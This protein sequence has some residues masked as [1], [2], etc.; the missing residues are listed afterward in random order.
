MDP[1]LRQLLGETD[2]GEIEAI[3][4]LA[5]P[6]RTP[7]GVR[8]VARFGETIATCRIAHD[9]VVETWA[10]DAVVSLK[11]ARPFNDDEGTAEGHGAPPEDP[12]PL[13]RRPADLDTT[14]E[15]VIV[16]VIDWGFDFAHD[17][18]RNDDGSTRILALWDQTSRAGPVPQPYGYGHVFSRE[19]IDAALASPRPYAALGY[20]PGVADRG[21]QGCHG[22]HVL[23]IAAGNGRLPGSPMGVAPR[24]EFLL[25]HLATRGTD[26][27]ANL[28][29]SVTLLEGLDWIRRQAGRR[30]WV[31]NMSVGR[32][33]GP[34]T[35]L[36]LVELG[37]D[38]LL[39]EAPGRCVVQSAGNYYASNVHSGGQ[40]RPGETR[41]L[42]WQVGAADRT[43]NEL[44]IW[45]SRHDGLGVTL[46]PPDGRGAMT[47]PLGGDAPILS[48][49]RTVGHFY[50]RA[51]DPSN[52]DNHV[53]IFLETDAPPGEW[54]VRLYG[55]DV[56][57]GR[58][59]CWVERDS[60]CRTCQSRL[61]PQDADP[62]STTGTICNSQRSIA[63]G[64]Y[65]AEDPD[66]PLARFSSAGPTVDGRIKPDLVA[67]G[68]Q[69]WAARSTPRRSHTPRPALVA[70]SGTSMAAPHVTGAVANMFEAA[71]RALSIEETRRLLLGSTEPP[72][73][74]DDP[75]RIGS[76]YL[77]LS[78][79]VAATRA[80]V[81]A[82]PL[83]PYPGERLTP[84]PHPPAASGFPTADIPIRA[85]LTARPLAAAVEATRESP[86]E[87]AMAHERFIPYAEN[88]P[89]DAE[90]L[91]ETAL[92]EAIPGQ[93]LYDA[94]GAP[95]G[96]ADLFDSLAGYHGEAMR[97]HYQQFVEVVGAP[98]ESVAGQLRPGDILL[99][100]AFGEG[101]LASATLITEDDLDAFDES[102]DC[103][104]PD[105]ECVRC[106]RA[107]R[108]RRL[109]RNRLVV[110]PRAAAD[111]AM[112]YDE[113]VE[114]LEW[115]LP[116]DDEES[117][118]DEAV[119]APPMA[120]PARDPV[121]FA[122][123]PP[124]G[125]YW[126]I[127]TSHP[128]GR[129]VNYRAAD[130]SYVGAQAGRAFLAS[131]SSGARYHVGIDLFAN[132]GD[133]VVA[134][135]DGRVISFYG[136]CCGKQMTTNALLVEHS[137]VVVNYGEVAPDSLRRAGLAIGSSVTAGQVI[138][139]VGRNPGGSSMIHF[140]TYVPGTRRNSRF[141]VGSR[142]P[143]PLLNP[144]SYLLWLQTHGRTP[145]GSAGGGAGSGATGSAGTGT[146]TGS[147]SSATGTLGALLSAVGSAASAVME[148]LSNGLW[149]N[150]V[151]LAIAGGQRDPN[152]LTNMVFFA[153]HPERNGRPL[154]Q[155]EADFARL[156]REWLD[157]RNN[158]VRPA[159]AGGASEGLDDDG[160][161]GAEALETSGERA[162]QQAPNQ[163][164]GATPLTDAEWHN[165][166]LWLG[167]G[168]VGVEPLTAD[169]DRNALIVAEAIFCGRNLTRL[170]T[171]TGEDPLLCVLSDVTR[172]DPRV[173]QLV[174]FVTAR[175]PIVHWPRVSEDERILYA[176]RRLV[177]EYRF[178]VNGA[179][180]LVGNLFAESGVLPSRIEGSG[181]ATPLTARHCNGTTATFSA[182]EVMNRTC[183]VSKARP[184]GRSNPGQGPCMPGIGLAQWTTAARRRELFQH[185]F[186]GRPA[187]ARILFDMDAQLDYLNSELTGRP[188][189]AGVDR[190][191]RRPTVGV[192]EASDEVVYNFEIPGAVLDAQNHKLPRSNPAVQAVF[193][194]RRGLSQRALRVY[195]ARHPAAA[196][197]LDALPDFEAELDDALPEQADES[198]EPS[199]SPHTGEWAETFLLDEEVASAASQFVRWV[200]SSLNRVLGLS[201]AVD[202]V[203][204]TQTRQAIR[205]FQ[206]REGLT[207]D[208]I[209]GPQTRSALTRAVQRLGTPGTAA[210][211]GGS[212]GSTISAC[213]GLRSPEVID[214]FEFNRSEVLPSH[215]PQIIRIARCIVASQ[216]TASP[217][218]NLDVVGHTDPVGTDAANLDLG[219]RRA[220][221]VKHELLRTI[222]RILPGTAARIV[223]NA[224][225]QGETRPVSSPDPAASRR[226]EV[227][228]T[229]PTMPRPTVPPVPPVTPPRIPPEPPEVPDNVRDLLRRVREA[230]E[231]VLQWV[232]DA[233]RDTLCP[234]ITAPRNLR[235]L[236]AAEQ[237]EARSVY[238][239]SL[240]FSR[241]IITDGLGCGGRP[242]TVAFPVGSDWWV[243]LN[244]G[245]VAS[246][247][248]RPRSDTLIHELAHAWQSQH[249]G[250]DPTAFMRNSIINQAGAAALTALGLEASAYAYIPGKPFA[251]YGAEQIAEQVEDSYNGTG[252]PTPAVARHVRSVAAG[253]AD[254][255]NEASLSVST[256][257]ERRST[258]G[259]VWP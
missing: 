208:G 185:V 80:W 186:Q 33:G 200:Q 60:A 204:G 109:A 196:E 71:G 79:A 66:R 64:A 161:E 136:F 88:E 94:T 10:D 31:V 14:G 37:I 231:S 7:P 124:A 57:D 35:G 170:V 164:I 175:G 85:G 171:G 38:A 182:E 149:P 212:S 51:R 24:A 6:P 5:T 114:A 41:R 138:G 52:G 227:F 248:T 214:R 237:A 47:V 20:H 219:R 142:R 215:Q 167:R 176:M 27:E 89:E 210:P 59:N 143:A 224:S 226:V 229:L 139:Y 162:L 233:V 133:P 113:D 95:A 181:M 251:E 32:H 26:G 250:S 70:N 107:G 16:A 239:G 1:A 188:G 154:A 9:Q 48:G 90:A 222:D 77:D 69:V 120:V 2:S 253:V 223:I 256:A 75:M 58:Y 40:L 217:I 112:E 22:T 241:I 25:V 11:A 137:N 247:A 168:E 12:A 23:D 259:V 172:A 159:L 207:V 150:A 209:V 106:R 81:R 135:E 111:T 119:P 225:S 115:G 78:R 105:C 30:P 118:P 230:L 243:A 235:F 220:E 49:S 131:R 238:A 146:S 153:R 190:L 130:G 76:G 242:F 211:T 126:P 42:R 117:Y 258:S 191:L 53:D 201:L 55:D 165:L 203:A 252:S 255:D 45:Y 3:I 44:E 56:I 183:S 93:S 157:I 8:L 132:L 73:P 21:G 213:A 166:E 140:E 189:F 193:R 29:D 145:G 228:M 43:P 15:G 34:H 116:A 160:A 246:F 244:Q 257:F 249:H 199:E 74:D 65:D 148:A 198:L 163:P 99:E 206:T 179:A 254:P 62:R 54:Q 13:D 72:A 180:G 100:R 68:V 169:A 232:P 240:D 197:D 234:G 86:L 83:Q 19:D 236:S 18:F 221:A 39:N 87:T 218:S 125:S 152:A 134:I 104:H 36:T 121:P 92:A 216:R 174:P 141:P 101:S 173:R 194:R 50:H 98:G 245:T 178:P 177:D 147:N 91:I 4:R 202:G 195:R 28:G 97:R 61:H 184:C 123:D 128:R 67:P 102:S 151:R 96:V 158:L 187:G 84:R 144:T 17:N 122:P 46:I 108:R 103:S 155:G 127:V 205:Q 63:V 110:R 129:E 82:H 156:S 192:D